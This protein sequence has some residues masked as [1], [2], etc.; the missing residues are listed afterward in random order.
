[1][2]QYIDV[3]IVTDTQAEADDI[4]ALGNDTILAIPYGS[5][6]YHGRR[7]RRIIIA[8]ECKGPDYEREYTSV[9][10]SGLRR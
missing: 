9:L 7:Y 5:T 2:R 4:N 1:M 6:L 10:K 8:Y 3:L